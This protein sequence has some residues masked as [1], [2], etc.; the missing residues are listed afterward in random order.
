MHSLIDDLAAVRALIQL[1]IDGS[2]GDTA[3]LEQAFHGDARMFGRIGDNPTG[4]GPIADFISY[5]GEN[6]GNAGP[7]YL[8]Y[9]RTIDLSGDAGVAVLVETDYLGHDFVDYFSVARIDGVWKITNKTYA[10]VGLT[11]PP[12]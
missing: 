4:S 2:N 9:V 6:P 1:Y 11:Q 8:A 12:S 7:N 3:K 10:E 5:I